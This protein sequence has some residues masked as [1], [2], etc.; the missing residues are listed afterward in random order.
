[1][2]IS[3]LKLLTKSQIIQLVKSLPPKFSGIVA[4]GVSEENKKA[5]VDGV[6]PYIVELVNKNSDEVFDKW[7]EFDL[8]KSRI[9]VMAW[10]DKCKWQVG[11]YLYEDHF[12]IPE[13]KKGIYSEEIKKY[14]ETYKEAVSKM[15]KNNR[16]L[17]YHN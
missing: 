14:N 11:V 7:G 16:S 3:N 15:I 9:F 5:S 2:A 17:Y 8:L 12:E 4:F 10:D 1:M 6:N 13:Y